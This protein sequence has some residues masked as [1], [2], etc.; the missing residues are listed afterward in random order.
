MHTR[1]DN[2]LD[3]VGH[4][5]LVRL[6]RMAADREAAIYVKLE[7]ANPGGSVKD[8]SGAAVVEAAE[9]SGQLRPGSVVVEAVTGHSGAG[10]A[11]T[12]AAKGYRCVLVVSEDANPEAV[13]LLKAYGAEVVVAPANSGE[14][15]HPESSAAVARR[16]ADEIPN[17]WQP[18]LLNNLE[19]PNH[20]Y[21]VTGPE[22]WYQTEGTVT[23]L[24]AGV[25]TGGTISGVGRYLKE[26][27]PDV[28]VVAAIA[29]GEPRGGSERAAIERT[30]E[31]VPKNFNAQ[32]VD[33][34]VPVPLAES[35]AA[36]RNLARQEGMLVGGTSGLVLAAALQFA[37]R[38]G[39]ND[40]IVAICSE[41]GRND[42]YQMHSDEWMREQGYL[43]PAAPTR[44]V[45]DLLNERGRS[46]L[47]CLQADESAERA[48]RL[49]RENDISQLPVLSEGEVVGAIRE[50]TL[51]RL[52]HDGS[53]PKQVCVGEIMGQPLP[54]VDE[55]AGL[56]EVYRLLSSSHNGVV[57]CRQGEVIDIITQ[58]DLVDFWNNQLALDDGADGGGVGGG[59]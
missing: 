54:T 23:V 55:N 52:L 16:L 21:H 27:N 50:L 36:A 5:P 48:V 58:I 35:Y 13:A 22:I 31:R 30:S 12:C 51:A 1:C 19:N 14:A 42:L 28:T 7:A 18:N 6:N 25:G 46:S 9:E 2:I 20:H 33:A 47:I 49:L 56:D 26:R 10:L 4:T 3:A 24:V 53:D 15:G 57:V 11:M 34:W 17:A 40:L 39:P 32:V 29:E 44:Y 59:I 41:T 37:E 38:R 43:R 45:A 8:R